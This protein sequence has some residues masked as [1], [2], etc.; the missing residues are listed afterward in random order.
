M[1]E[2]G[3]EL[4]ISDVLLEQFNADS[5]CGPVFLVGGEE[6]PKGVGSISSPF[7]DHAL[8]FEQV[9]MPSFACRLHA[10]CIWAEMRRTNHLVALCARPSPKLARSLVRPCPEKT[11]LMEGL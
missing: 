6:L 5:G 2:T 9:R 10:V 3:R 8:G 4:E 7:Q 1:Q 11:G